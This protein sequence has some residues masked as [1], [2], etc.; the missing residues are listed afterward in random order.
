M[1]LINQKWV[2]FFFFP[3]KNG[4]ESQQPTHL[5]NYST[6]CI[7]IVYKTRKK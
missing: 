3:Y 1:H 6:G 2:G 4:G 5:I 7:K